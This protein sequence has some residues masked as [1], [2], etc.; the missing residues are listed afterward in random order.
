MCWIAA[1]GELL[2]RKP[3]QGLHERLSILTLCLA[4]IHAC[5]VAAARGSGCLGVWFAWSGSKMRAVR[6]H[7]RVSII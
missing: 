2:E 5:I 4:M 7:G 1:R 3:H 6:E